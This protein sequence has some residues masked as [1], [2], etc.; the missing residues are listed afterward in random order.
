MPKETIQFPSVDGTIA[1]ETSVRWTREEQG[2]HVQISIRRHSQGAVEVRN[3]S[4]EVIAWM[5]EDRVADAVIGTSQILRRVLGADDNE[6]RPGLRPFVDVD[7][8]EGDGHAH[9][10]SRDGNDTCTV[11]NVPLFVGEPPLIKR[12]DVVGDG[13][14]VDPT[15]VFGAVGPFAH[16]P[17]IIPS[18]PPVVV[19]GPVRTA[20]GGAYMLPPSDNAELAATEPDGSVLMWTD[21]LDRNSINK[22]IKVLRRARDQAYGQDE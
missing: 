4:G 8:N 11:C 5:P 17:P 13:G 2:G 12:D 18:E 21:P 22:L 14:Q 1:T 20:L 9:T 3:F 15:K 6:D 19:E 10:L 7:G 16:F